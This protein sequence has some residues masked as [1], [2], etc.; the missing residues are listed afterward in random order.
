[1]PG[2]RLASL[3]CS[4]RVRAFWFVQGVN[5]EFYVNDKQRHKGAYDETDCGRVGLICIFA[6]DD[7]SVRV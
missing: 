2:K 5:L 6:Q 3:E 4:I 1:M 7:A